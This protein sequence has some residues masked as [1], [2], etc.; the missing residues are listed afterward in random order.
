MTIRT[1]HLDRLGEQVTTA[2]IWIFLAVV[3]V[4]LLWLVAVV[5]FRRC[6]YRTSVARKA[7]TLR[8]EI[9]ERF[10]LTIRRVSRDGWV[11]IA[12]GESEKWSRPG[13]RDELAT[14][15]GE[16][17]LRLKV[18]HGYVHLGFAPELPTGED[19]QRPMTF[20]RQKGIVTCGYNVATGKPDGFTLR[21]SSLML[22]AAKPGGGKTVFVD[23]V[24]RCLQS[25][26]SVEV[27]EEFDGKRQS[28]EEIVPGLRRVQE[29]MENSWWLS[30]TSAN[31]F[32][33]RKAQIKRRN[34]LRNIGHNWSLTLWNEADR[35]EC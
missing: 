2:A 18:E 1:E 13:L 31:A 26:D 17:R 22:V 9:K 34:K 8:G 16:S 14:F 21:E 29:I 28:P 12:P 7:A 11:K 4:G 19:M 32:L 24:V 6:W 20:D 33:L 25:S 15:L 27:L 23:G 3:G 5:A 35:V 10:G 30:S